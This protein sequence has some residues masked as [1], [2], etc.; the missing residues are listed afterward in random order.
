MSN[1]KGGK[2]KTARVKGRTGG[3]GRACGYCVLC[4]AKEIELY[5]TVLN[6]ADQRH[7]E[8]CEAAGCEHRPYY[9]VASDAEHGPGSSKRQKAGRAAGRRGAKAKKERSEGLDQVFRRLKRETAASE[10]EFAFQEGR[11]WTFAH[12]EVAPDV[13]RRVL[14]SS[15]E[16]LE[17]LSGSRE[18]IAQAVF[19][20]LYPSTAGDRMGAAE[21]W[22]GIGLM[23][24]TVPTLDYVHSFVK[25]VV[26]T[27]IY[28]RERR[29]GREAGA[30]YADAA[31]PI[32]PG[33]LKDLRGVF[34]RYIKDQPRGVE[35]AWA[36]VFADGFL[37]AAGREATAA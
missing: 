4:R 29:N 11:D 32:T 15:V 23:R 18:Q 12:D 10:R 27:A 22:G 13:L 31:G 9:V 30:A 1:K 26:A 8:A 37:E 2:K 34:R 33:D 28:C 21:L 16:L 7:V 25:G 36:R 3:G 5:G 19:D 35:Q 24:P 14:D 6:T 17:S 20:W